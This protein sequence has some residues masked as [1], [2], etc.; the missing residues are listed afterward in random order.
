MFDTNALKRLMHDT[1]YAVLLPALL[2]VAPALMAQPGTVLSHQKISD[3]AGG[4][5][6]TLDDI[7]TFGFSVAG[8]GIWTQ[9]GSRISSSEPMA[10]TTGALI[11]GRC[12]SCF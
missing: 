3:T 9:T 5:A 12:G 8:I 4:L 11:V 7:D 10:T 2:L 6:G 1:A